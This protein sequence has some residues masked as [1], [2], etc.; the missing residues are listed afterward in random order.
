MKKFVLLNWQKF[1]FVNTLEMALQALAS[2]SGGVVCPGSTQG[3][4]RGL[5]SGVRGWF[6]G[7][8][9]EKKFCDGKQTDG[10]TDRRDG[11]NSDLDLVG[12]RTDRNL[13]EQLNVS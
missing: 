4:P 9:S 7:D 11:W 1:I 8:L 5:T 10:R 13:D 12:E 3:Q 6:L 2:S